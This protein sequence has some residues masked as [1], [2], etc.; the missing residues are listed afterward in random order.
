MPRLLTQ[1]DVGDVTLLHGR[2]KFPYPQV[3]FRRSEL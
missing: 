3:K 2:P 1:C